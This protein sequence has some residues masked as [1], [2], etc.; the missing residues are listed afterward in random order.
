MPHVNTS[1][2]RMSWLWVSQQLSPQAAEG[3]FH[4]CRWGLTQFLCVC[5]CF[6]CLVS[7]GWLVSVD[8][9]RRRQSVPRSP[10]LTRMRWFVCTVETHTSSRM[11]RVFVH[12]TIPGVAPRLNLGIFYST[13]CVCLPLTCCQRGN[14]RRPAT[15]PPAT[16]WCATV[17]LVSWINML[18]YKGMSVAQ[19]WDRQFTCVWRRGW[20]KRA[21]KGS[22]SPACKPRAPKPSQPIFH[23]QFCMKSPKGLSRSWLKLR[24]LVSKM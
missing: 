21:V 5:L 18:M 9:W 13:V 10:V 24:F 4:N 23:I 12:V 8:Q 15:L 1:W 6:I 11:P 7:L 16:S 20:T 14:S 2:G 3:F 17:R 22:S 19:R